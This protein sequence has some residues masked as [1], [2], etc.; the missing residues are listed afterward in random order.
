MI[1]GVSETG[2]LTTSAAAETL[3][4]EGLPVSLAYLDV[5]CTALGGGLCD[6]VAE[7]GVSVLGSTGMHM[8]YAPTPDD[9]RLNE[10]RSGYTMC[11]PIERACASMQSNMAATLNIDWL[12][13]MAREAAEMAGVKTSRAALL[14]G[15]DE[16]ALGTDP[17]QAV[18]H[19]YIFEAGE[20][21]PFLN[22]DARAQF[23]GLST[24]TSFAGL[25]RAVFEG[26]AF[27]TRD[28]TR[29]RLD[30]RRSPLRRRRRT[31]ESDARHSRRGA[32]RERAHAHAG[33]AWRVESAM[34][35]AVNI[36]VIEHERVRRRMETTPSPKLRFRT[37]SLATITRRLRTRPPNHQSGHVAG[38]G[39]F[40]SAQTGV[41]GVSKEFERRRPIVSII[42]DR[43]MLPSMF[44]RA[45]REKCGEALEIRSYEMP[46]PDEP[47][48]HGYAEHGMEGLKEYQGRP[49]KWLRT[50]MP[51][52]RRHP[53]LAPFSDRVL[54][55]LPQLKLIA[56]SRGGPVNI[57]MAAARKRKICVVNTPGR[58]ASAVA[59]FAIGAILAEDPPHYKGAR[60]SPSRRM[61]WRSLPRRSYRRRIVGN[62]S[63]RDRLWAYRDQVVRILK[64]FGCRIL[65]CDPYVQLSA[66][67]LRD[68]VVRVSLERLLRESD[69][70]TLHARVTEET[71]GFIGKEQFEQMKRGAYFVNTARGPMVYYDALTEALKTAAFARRRPETF[72]VEP[73]P[74]NLELLQL[75]NVTLTPHIAGGVG[76]DGQDR[77]CRPTAGGSSPLPSGGRS[78]QS[79]L[80]RRHTE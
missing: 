39:P 38:L 37:R 47:M 13:D 54:E 49:T 3:L 11:L 33:G 42:G 40:G 59:E 68:G 21:G 1:D 77:R 58:N 2:K 76:K 27:A 35:A 46:W 74:A 56:V 24:Q 45:I 72:A 53:S 43:F 64:V 65:V 71:R 7:V 57:D 5:V 34:M 80:N 62:D 78:P 50:W 73:A 25:A 26:L 8:R 20:R 12:M 32:Q 18:Y 36:G 48:E 28:C 67:D 14:S 55:R 51:L 44:E 30:P 79:L 75:D 29:F 16:R 22:P 63:R 31:V 41:R 69:V 17:G 23:S 70:V 9:V 19:P 10:D 52:S 4:P 60:R 66:D 6:P 15:L 61:A